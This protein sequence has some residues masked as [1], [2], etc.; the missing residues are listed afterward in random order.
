MDGP[1]RAPEAVGG[2]GE[3][4]AIVEEARY[5]LAEAVAAEL[6]ASAPLGER[7][8]TSKDDP[9][10]LVAF[11]A[12][13]R[14]HWIGA[15]R[16]R[17]ETLF[18]GRPPP[19]PMT[20]PRPGCARVVLHVDMDCFFAAVA[21]AGRPALARVPLAVSW[22]SGR[23]SGG[24]IS[25]ANYLARAQG[26]RAGMW[27]KEARTLCPRLVVVP[28]EFDRFV[29]AGA[30]LYRALFAISPHVAPV[31]C[32]EAYVDV[33]NFVRPSPL[34]SALYSGAPAANDGSALI[35]PE[36]LAAALRGNILRATGGCAASVGI[37]PNRLLA[38]LATARAK[39]DG[40]VS[41]L[42]CEPAA[43][44]APLG[45]RELPGVGRE[46]ASK[47]ESIGVHCCAELAAAAA[48]G[49]DGALA[50]L[51]GARTARQLG[52]LARGDDDR[53]WPSTGGGGEEG[54]DEGGGR[55]SFGA[56]ASWGVRFRD[57]AGVAEFVRQLSATIAAKAVAR[58]AR[59]RH[60]SVRVWEAKP[61]E[62]QR[63]GAKG[64][65]GHGDCYMR[66]K[67]V[68]LRE[69]MGDA[70][71]LG[72][73]ALELVRAL[74]IPPA[75]VRGLGVALA[76]LAFAKPGAGGATPECASA[77]LRGWALPMARAEPELAHGAPTST[78][79]PGGAGGSGV[80]PAGPLARLW[81]APLAKSPSGAKRRLEALRE[82]GA[83][84]ASEDDD[85]DA[86]APAAEEEPP[87]PPAVPKFGGGGGG[88]NDSRDYRQGKRARQAAELNQIG[89]SGRT[90]GVEHPGGGGGG[91][92]GGG[93]ARF[94]EGVVLWVD[95]HTN[96]PAHELMRLCCA[97]GG[98]FV[99]AGNFG[100]AGQPLTHVITQTVRAG[101]VEQTVK[102]MAIATGGRGVSR[103][104]IVT[105]EWLVQSVRAGRKLD[106]RAFAVTGTF[107]PRQ[108]TLFAEAPRTAMPSR[109]AEVLA[110]RLED[111][112]EAAGGARAG[113]R[114]DVAAR[115]E[116]DLLEPDS[117]E[118]VCSPV[119]DNGH[120]WD[121]LELGGFS[122][123]ADSALP[124]LEQLD[125]AVFAQLP[126]E[127][128]TRVRQGYARRGDAWPGEREREI[129]RRE[130][131]HK[132]GQS[133]RGEGSAQTANA[134][135]GGK[136]GGR[137]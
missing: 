9:E 122:Q 107:D 110:T 1:A 114:A 30:A 12:N 3:E 74:A 39:P 88:W 83:A 121:E 112:A 71:S 109:G 63:Y 120:E 29:T 77:G 128:Q 118:G 73:R 55:K 41:L 111:A 31:S 40:C 126:P 17:F 79:S 22:S 33:T 130:H 13:S 5:R 135:P 42:G 96:P 105:P 100:K 2:A 21:A 97:H 75:S 85:D 81:A 45:I 134:W 4:E 123:L 49:P 136:E 94:L 102:R 53:P 68:T 37:G 26:V 35:K 104:E 66:S 108:G 59:G 16:E 119:P 98:T 64:S 129:E 6:R 46:R 106:T 61:E 87:P 56:Q 48:A 51:L 125:A 113:G 133:E 27:C 84:C 117:A 50:R 132:N 58:G 91:G 52:A 82:E 69:S 7:L 92:G 57:E 72:A 36:A 54:G 101:A 44:F 95:G 103:R 89:A 28:Y 131:S 99:P 18:S 38:R 127:L 60:V 25:S 76:G 34:P 65:V 124:P 116:P 24:E 32:D 137:E 70:A 11:H 78:R 10:F 67:A 115:A 47:L 20:S 14:L 23:E 15:W 90:D 93:A 8:R 62:L 86:A 19:P 43:L 80:H